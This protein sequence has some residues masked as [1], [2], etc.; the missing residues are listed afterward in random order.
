MDEYSGQWTQL[1]HRGSTDDNFINKIRNK[2]HF[3]GT[4]SRIICSRGEGRI[5][6]QWV[7]GAMAGIAGESEIA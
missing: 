4:R 5:L 2:D 1:L 3:S 6:L 7:T